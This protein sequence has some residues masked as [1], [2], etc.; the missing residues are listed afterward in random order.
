MYRVNVIYK[1]GREIVFE[2][3]SELDAQAF[4]VRCQEDDRVVETKLLRPSKDR[5]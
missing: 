5:V 1:D 2:R 3:E 4:I